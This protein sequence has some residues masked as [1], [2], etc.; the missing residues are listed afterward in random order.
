[1]E[2]GPHHAIPLSVG[3]DF[4]KF[5]APND[6][7]FFLHHAQIDKLWWAWQQQDLPKRGNEYNGPSRT[8]SL[9]EAA[10][11]DLIEMW[12]LGPDIEVRQMMNTEAGDLCYRY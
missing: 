8:D 5:S 9:R 6:P 11:E 12:E 1:M 2:D 7:V 10:L 3:G 4:W